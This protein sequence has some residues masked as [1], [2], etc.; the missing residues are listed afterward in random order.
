M[1]LETALT[2]TDLVVA[3]GQQPRESSECQVPKMVLGQP[4]SGS[5]ES[6]KIGWANPIDRLRS[7]G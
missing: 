5:Q 1:S 3:A 2:G 6:A 4:R 7:Q